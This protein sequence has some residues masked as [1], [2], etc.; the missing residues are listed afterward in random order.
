MLVQTER[1]QVHLN[2]CLGKRLLRR[3]A[4][5]VQPSIERFTLQS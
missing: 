4:A 5:E 1:S 2:S 3:Q